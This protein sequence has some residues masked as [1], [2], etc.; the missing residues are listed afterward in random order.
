MKQIT[1]WTV[2]FLVLIMG[3]ACERVVDL[4]LRN[5]T[6]R[7]VIEGMITDQAGPQSIQLSRNVEFSAPNNYPTVSGAVVKVTD[8]KGHRFDFTETAPGLYTAAEMQGNYGYHYTMEVLLNDTTYTASSTMPDLVK[9]DSLSTRK[10]EFDDQPNAKIITAHYSDPI[11]LGNQ[12]QFILYVNNKIIN[13]VFTNNDRLSDGRN[14][15]YDLQL[16]DDITILPGDSVKVIMQC[17]DANIFKY[18]NAIEQQNADGPGGGAAPANPP[19]NISPEALGY[20]SA[21]TIE[22]IEM[23][24]K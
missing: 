4:H 21:N 23:V 2:L 1:I 15:T 12:Y 11:G 13:Q 22:S 9:L 20:F 16:N 14:V 8:E 24:V 5:E 18:W 6:G 17:I 10:D 7:L 3:V 19:S